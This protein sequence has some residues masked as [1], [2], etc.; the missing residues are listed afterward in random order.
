[1]TAKKLNLGCGLQCPQDW[2]NVDCSFGARLAKYPKLKKLLHK[3]VPKKLGILPNMKWPSNVLCMDITSKL[4]FKENSIDYIYSSHTL[5]HMAYNEGKQIIN[6]CYRVLKPSGII[7]I[8]V[9]DLDATIRSYLSNKQNSPIDAALN[10]HKNTFYFEIPPPN[11]LIDLIKYYFKRKNNHFFLYDEEALRNHLEIEGFKEIE[12][13]SYGESL[14][15][16]IKSIDEEDRF[17][18][19]ICLEGIK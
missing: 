17:K 12:R 9:P 14:I 2:I 19:A 15:P 18:G 1:M 5:E 11:N 6:E 16:D 10:F 8:I 3:V 13:K 7:R 4:K